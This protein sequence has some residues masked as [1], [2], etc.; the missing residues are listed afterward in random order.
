MS[1]TKK[2]HMCAGGSDGYVTIHYTFD[3]DVLE[4]F[5]DKRVEEF[6]G[7]DSETYIL[8]PADATYESLGIS[9]PIE[10]DFYEGEL[11]DI[12]D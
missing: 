9:Y 4:R 6:G 8:V 12:E 11:R 5:M 2:L 1:Q 3:A 10:Q 7:G